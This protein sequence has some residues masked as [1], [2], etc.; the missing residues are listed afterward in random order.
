MVAAWL[1]GPANMFHED[2]GTVRLH[3]RY[4]RDYLYLV[5]TPGND[6]LY[7]GKSKNDI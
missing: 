7:V 6:Q 1:L 5:A 3:R 4:M 2:H